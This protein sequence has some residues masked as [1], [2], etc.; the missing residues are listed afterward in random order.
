MKYIRSRVSEDRRLSN[1]GS[2]VGIPRDNFLGAVLSQRR[3]I[4]GKQSI[5]ANFLNEA[6]SGPGTY[7]GKPLNR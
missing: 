2:V 5:W 6:G 7:V 3:N 4:E 1:S